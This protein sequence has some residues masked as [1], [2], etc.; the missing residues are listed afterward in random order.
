MKPALQAKVMQYLFSK[1]FP[2]GFTLVELLVVVIIIGILTAIALPTFLNQTVKAK[3]AE[4]KNTIGTV[5]SG[6][7]AFR[8]INSRFAENFS[9]LALGLP[10]HTANYTYHI[11]TSDNDFVQ[12]TAQA[13]NSALKGYSG[14]TERYADSNGQSIISSV[15]CEAPT[16]GIDAPGVPSPSGPPD[17]T[18]VGMVT[19]GR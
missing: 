5:N 17:C 4:A 19:M 9:Q 14:V 13:K 6:Q 18:S 7:T 1:N 15:V 3:Q 10:E 11:L 16:P 12:I 8:V 2:Q